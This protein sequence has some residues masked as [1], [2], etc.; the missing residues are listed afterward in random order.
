MSEV[1]THHSHFPNKSEDLG[2]G[3]TTKLALLGFLMG[4]FRPL[5]PA[6]C[7]TDMCA[8]NIRL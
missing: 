2:T 7:P 3:S 6:S 4:Q 5:I 8:D 1:I